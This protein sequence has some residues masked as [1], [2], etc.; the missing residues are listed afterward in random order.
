MPS[1]GEGVSFLAG[2]GKDKQ[3]ARLKHQSNDF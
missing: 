2:Q 1:I 3:G